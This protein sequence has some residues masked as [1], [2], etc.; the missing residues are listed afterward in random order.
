MRREENRIPCPCCDS[1]DYDF[2]Y[3]DAF[4]NVLGCSECVHAVDEQI[5]QE[6]VETQLYDSHIDYL[7]DEAIG[8]RVCESP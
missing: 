4:D 1:L 3:M 2:V 8:R 5:Y 6:Q 7:I